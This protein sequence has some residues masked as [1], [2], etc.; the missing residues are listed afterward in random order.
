MKE[1]GVDDADDDGFKTPVSMDHKIPV[2]QQCPPAPRKPK[3]KP[4]PKPYPLTI[5]MKRRKSVGFSSTALGS[6]A[7]HRCKHA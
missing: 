2:L 6:T 3:P 5:T 1:N 4:K 7:V